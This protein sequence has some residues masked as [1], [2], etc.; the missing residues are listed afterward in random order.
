MQL[1]AWEQ[2]SSIELEP[3]EVGGTPLTFRI[4]IQR[5]IDDGPAAYRARLFQAGSDGLVR[6]DNSFA[7][8]TARTFESGADAMA[9]VFVELEQRIAAPPA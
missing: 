4:E 1:V 6:S 5:R 7:P 2:I 3:L 8:S 9:A